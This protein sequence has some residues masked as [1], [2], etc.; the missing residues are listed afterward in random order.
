MRT[1]M[2]FPLIGPKLFKFLPGLR[3][4]QVIK[5]DAQR[6]Q[7]DVHLGV[8]FLRNQRVHGTSRISW[9]VA[10]ILSDEANEGR[11]E[12]SEHAGKSKLPA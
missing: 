8:G 5:R 9:L 10:P 3:D 2:H 4:P 11:A 12:R 7:R 1:G 6:L